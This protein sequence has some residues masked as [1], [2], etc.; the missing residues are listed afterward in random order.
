MEGH[1]VK[2]FSGGKTVQEALMDFIL[3]TEVYKQGTRPDQ[4]CSQQD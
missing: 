3:E 4:S 2:K 1:E